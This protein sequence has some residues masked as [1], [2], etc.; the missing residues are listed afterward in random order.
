MDASREGLGGVLYQKQNC[1]LHLIVYVSC[2]LTPSV[3]N[4]PVHKL[5]FLALKWAIVDKLIII[6]MELPL[7]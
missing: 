3:K 7:W 1:E 4:Y 2:N 6:R 5:E